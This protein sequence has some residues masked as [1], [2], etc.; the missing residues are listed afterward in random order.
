MRQKILII[1]ALGALL[2]ILVFGRLFYQPDTP[3][4]VGAAR[5]IFGISGGVDCSYRMIKPLPLLFSGLLEKITALPAE[6]GFF[7]QNI[8]FFILAALLIFQ[9]LQTIFNQN[10][11]LLGT[12]AFISSPPMLIF[13]LAY[14]TDMA[15]WFFGLLGIFLTIRHFEILKEKKWPALTLGGLM[16][17]GFLY[18]ESA[19]AAPLFLGI[20]T[21]FNQ[22]NKKQKINLILLGALG[23]L[24]PVLISSYIIDHYFH[25]SF[26]TWFRFAQEKPFGDYYRLLPFIKEIGTTL[27]LYWIFFVLGAIQL[28]KLWRAGGLGQKQKAFLWASGFSLLL[29]VIWSYPS[30]RI[31]YLSSP[32]LF[33]LVSSGAMVL[34]KNTRLTIFLSTILLQFLILAQYLYLDKNFFWPILVALLYYLGLGLYSFSLLKPRAQPLPKHQ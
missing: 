4:Y 10:Q 22:I 23:F 8:I 21:L 9:L 2:I 11:A 34:P 28:I 24:I 26:L 13:G 5:L 16:G 17:L 32:F 31:F 7:I 27:Y 20:Y 12:L 29:W 14:L 25:Y 18:K 19:L 1:A 30:N 6:H 3:C 15:G 33:S